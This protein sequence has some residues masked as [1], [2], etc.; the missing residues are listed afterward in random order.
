MFTRMFYYE[1]EGEW[2]VVRIDYKNKQ[3]ETP[4]TY[5]NKDSAIDYIIAHGL[6]A[7]LLPPDM[8]L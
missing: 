2:H 7:N 6:E 8:I 1:K 4:W 5:K 3:T